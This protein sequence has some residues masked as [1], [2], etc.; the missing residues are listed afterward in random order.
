[1]YGRT[2]SGTTQRRPRDK[3]AIGAVNTFLGDAVGR[4]Y[5]DRFF[6]A[7][8]KADIQGMVKNILAAFDARVAALD[9]MS[10]ATKAEARKKIATI[11][12]GIGYAES[13]R[14]YRG[15]EIK[16]DDPVGNIARAGL[17]EYRHQISKIGKPPDPGEWWMTPQTVNAVNLPLQNALN[18]PAAIL[19]APFYD[20]RADPAAN[21][22]SIG[23]VIGHEISHSFDNTGAEFD[24]S[25]KL[26]Q[27]WTPADYAHFKQ[28]G[29]ALVAQYNAYEPL[30]GLHIN[31]AQ[32]LGENIADAAGL[33]AALEAYHASLGG[34]PAPVLD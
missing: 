28:A 7:S 32:T 34:N 10:P 2:L 29:A 25:G 27:W 31:G 1:L 24:A 13:W 3:R 6:P 33:M 9:W 22:G 11:R 5:A 4:I 17:A 19:E 16:P 14:D 8:S 12:V 26:R 23:A 20:P 30:P 18:F 21:Y 15:L